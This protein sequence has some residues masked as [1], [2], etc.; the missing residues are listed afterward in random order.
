M[1]NE[2]KIDQLRMMYNIFMRVEST[3][4]YKRNYGFLYNARRSKNYK[5][6]RNLKR[7][8]YFYPK[9]SRFKR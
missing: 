2:K 5:E 9:T 3:L 6:L 8:T 1:F 7:S 4:K